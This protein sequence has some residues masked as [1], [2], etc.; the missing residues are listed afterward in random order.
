[1]VTQ[2]QGDWPVGGRAGRPAGAG[3][4]SL[5]PCTPPTAACRP[6]PCWPQRQK[7]AEAAAST[8]AATAATQMRRLKAPCFVPSSFYPYRKQGLPAGVH[9]REWDSVEGRGSPGSRQLP[10]TNLV[11][12]HASPPPPHHHTSPPPPSPPPPTHPPPTTHH[13]HPH[14]QRRATSPPTPRCALAA[15]WPSPG[16]FVGVRAA[17]LLPQIQHDV[18][19]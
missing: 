9:S 17:L 3:S 10:A 13:P 2:Q 18:R 5:V 4:A 7:Q 6:L 12:A 8:A 16:R 1:M 11:Y 14:L 19:S 15:T